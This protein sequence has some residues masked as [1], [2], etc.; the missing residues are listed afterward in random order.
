MRPA[1]IVSIL[2][3]V[4]VVLK[5]T[6]MCDIKDSHLVVLVALAVAAMC[7][8]PA[9]EG[10][11]GS[12]AAVDADAFHALNA[13]VKA[14]VRTEDGGTLVIPSN[15]K[16]LGKVTIAHYDDDAVL[17]LGDDTSAGTEN[18]AKISIAKEGDDVGVLKISGMEK[19]TTGNV[20]VEE[21][22]YDSQ[23][24]KS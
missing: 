3:V 18:N 11:T 1:Q 16:V 21:I 23:S 12:H 5:L 17:E 14:I 4:A 8:M 22:K 7:A 20:D 19:L 6:K 2:L 9:A 13:I 24:K 10:F 15:L